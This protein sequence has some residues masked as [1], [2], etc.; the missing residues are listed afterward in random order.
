MNFEAIATE[1]FQILRSYDYTCLLYDEDGNQVYEPSEA[2]RFFAK[3][4][5][6]LLS[7]IDKGEDSTVRL[8]VAKSLPIASIEGM[9][10]ALRVMSTKYSVVFNVREWARDEMSPKDFATKSSVAEGTRTE[11]NILEGMYGTSRSSYLRLEN[12]RMIIRH[13]ARINENMIG[14]RGRNIDSIYIENGVG[15]RM[16]FPTTNLAPARAMAH[17]VDNGGSWADP[18]GEQIGRMARDFSN[19]VSAS[20]HIQQHSGDLTESAMNVRAA[21]REQIVEMRRMFERVCRKTRYAE[22]T[23]AILDKTMAL[24]EADYSDRVTEL[25]SIINTPEV[26][27]S[28]A[29]LETVAR[30]LGEDEDEGK[31]KFVNPADL[32]KL[33]PRKVD[34]RL[35]GDF[36][37]DSKHIVMIMGRKVDAYA[38][39]DFKR[40]KL[41]LV[42]AP[43]SASEFKPTQFRDPLTKLAFD[44]GNLGMRCRDHSMMNLLSYVSDRL[45][46]A[47]GEERQKMIGV[48]RYALKIAG[49]KDDD[50]VAKTES[51]REFIE[52]M[53][54]FSTTKVLVEGVPAWNADPS[55]NGPYNDYVDGAGDEIMDDFD[56]EEFLASGHAE[57]IGWANRE[58]L[59]DMNLTK[60]EVVDALCGYL[61][62]E[63]FSRFDMHN[64]DMKQ[65]ANALYPKV[66]EVLSRDGFAI[67]ESI[68]ECGCEPGC[69]CKVQEGEDEWTRISGPIRDVTGDDAHDTAEHYNLVHTDK[70]EGAD[71]YDSPTFIMWN[72]DR[73]IK[74]TMEPIWDAGNGSHYTISVYKK[75]G[76]EEDLELS[77]EDVL[78]PKHKGNDLRNEVTQQTVTNPETGE[79]ELP[80]DGY[81]NRLQALAGVRTQF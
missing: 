18:V 38:W 2:R 12:A 6:L 81:I 74:M 29:I 46:D 41:D 5:N 37:G 24:H 39:Q 32:H 30:M 16:L 59:D 79:T 50:G 33:P 53:N 40:G 68:S 45:A 64:P 3:S 67:A 35:K 77:R 54:T 23:E 55:A 73:T 7:V 15:E 31:A 71:E 49:H 65:E 76:I 22:A 25:A 56:A 21:V 51:V 72:D 48:A 14:A 19:L 27:L 17:H 20:R 58:D 80:D 13:S 10:S 47:K 70:V 75:G 43:A 66:A 78:L 34:N 9:I 60:A 52:W 4:K 8:F 57:N 44:L 26:K 62:D 1:A 61:E 63:F 11:M 36:V 69:D 28:E 42:P